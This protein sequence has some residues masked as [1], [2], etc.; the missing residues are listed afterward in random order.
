MTKHRVYVSLLSGLGFVSLVCL[1]LN[2]PVAN[3]FLLALFTPGG[4]AVST[5]P[6]HTNWISI[7]ALLGANVVIY[8][9]LVFVVFLL[10]FKTMEPAKLTQ[11]SRWIVLPVAAVSCLACLP[12][13]N[14]LW[15]RGM[16]ELSKQESQLQNDLPVGMRLQDARSV[17]QAHKI[18]F[19]ELIEESESIVF[20]TAEK[21]IK[22]G[23]GD[24][25]FS[26][27][28]QTAVFSF[29]CGYDLQVILVFGR[30]ER[31]KA[32]YVHRLPICP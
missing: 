2:I 4:I 3:F 15:P 23:P 30:D 32:R 8:S 31:L 21:T 14:P 19:H 17:L 28:F 25:V 11:I 16:M 10:W 5:L 9:V 1:L 24:R 7:S 20:Q 29:P 12:S 26:S 22:A 6:W 18:Q 27:E 13:L